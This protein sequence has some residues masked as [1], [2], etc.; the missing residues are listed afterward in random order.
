MKNN[1]I[2]I[3]SLINDYNNG[4]AI[5]K[6]A[7]KYHIQEYKPSTKHYGAYYNEKLIAVMCFL[8]ENNNNW[9]MTSFASDYENRVKKAH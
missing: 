4:L 5:I 2:D 9:E 7:T 1:D 3:K 8:K 6:I